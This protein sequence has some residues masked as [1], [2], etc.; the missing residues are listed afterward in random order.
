M[1]SRPISA[2]LCNL[3]FATVAAFVLAGH[4][5]AQTELQTGRTRRRHT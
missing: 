4:A 3:T 1:I 2:L 5:S